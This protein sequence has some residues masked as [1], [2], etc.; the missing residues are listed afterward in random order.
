MLAELVGMAT[1]LG[2]EVPTEWNGGEEVEG[3]HT[4]VRTPKNGQPKTNLL[5]A[6]SDGPQSSWKQSL[7]NHL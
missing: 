2:M 6:P 3:R 4:G 1:A 5:S 7:R